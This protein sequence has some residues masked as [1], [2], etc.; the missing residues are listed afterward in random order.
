MNTQ[1]RAEQI[2]NRLLDGFVPKPLNRR[3]R[4][5]MHQNLQAP[6]Q[7]PEAHERAKRTAERYLSKTDPN[8]QVNQNLRASE[9]Q[10]QDYLDNLRQSAAQ[11]A[12]QSTR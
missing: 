9:R 11:P 3:A 5:D 2:V 4:R 6:T 12:Q 7:H 1:S 10:R 8:F